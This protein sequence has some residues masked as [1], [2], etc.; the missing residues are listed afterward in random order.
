MR[1]LRSS[2]LILVVAAL[3]V[4]QDVA[5]RQGVDVLRVGARLACLCGCSDTFATCSM[6]ECHFCKP[7]KA[8]IAKLQA[9]GISDQAIIDLYIKEFGHQIFRDKPNA[10]GWIIPY[11]ALLPGLG[12]IWWFVRRYYQPGS[13]PAAAAGPDVSRY[14]EQIEKELANLE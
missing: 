2:L 3:A 9:A 11:L 1:R 10:F 12:L 8:R 7:Q 5:R 6:L 13:A 4:A 14:S